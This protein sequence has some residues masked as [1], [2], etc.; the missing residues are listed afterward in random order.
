M[1]NQ[2]TTGR[3]TAVVV[4]LTLIAI[5]VL[6]PACPPD[7][8]HHGP[9]TPGLSMEFCHHGQT[10]H[11]SAAAPAQ[12]AVQTSPASVADVDLPSMAVADT[13]STFTSC[14]WRSEHV[15]SGRTLLLDLGISR[16]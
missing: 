2:L 16:T 7:P 5:F 11:L 4:A 15:S 13:S 14:P 1:R 6:H 3:R 12:A 9:S 10:Q 8:A